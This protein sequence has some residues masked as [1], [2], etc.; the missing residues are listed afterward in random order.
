MQVNWVPNK[1][2]DYSFV[3]E[4]LDESQQKNH[5]TN[6]GPNV[7]LLE[8]TVKELLNIEENKEVICVANGTL[9]LAAV[10][11]G[12]ELKNNR[13]ILFASQSFTFPAS[14]QGYLRNTIICDIDESGGI[15]LN[16]VP[17]ECDGIFVTNVFG[18]LTDID[19]YVNWGSKFNKLVIFDNA[20]TPYSFYSGKNSCNFGDASIVSFHHTKPIGFGEGG[21]IIIDKENAKYVRRVINFGFESREKPIWNMFSSNYKM[22]DVQAVFILQHLQ[23]FSNIRTTHEK[24]FKHFI[25]IIPQTIQLYPNQAERSLLS[26]IC[27]FVQDSTKKLQVLIDNNIYARKY[28]LPLIE[29]PVALKFYQDILCIPL[30]SDMNEKDI[31]NIVFL[32]ANDSN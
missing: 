5:F 11:A 24:L 31:K 26:C 29:S 30:H 28:Y 20:A 8:K 6:Y 14:V 7:I 3:K 13:S 32:L 15:D 23:Q 2:I 19:L 1:S 16:S 25:D 4:R 12:F 18:N 22:S 9:A 21:C 10:V 27:I 17:T